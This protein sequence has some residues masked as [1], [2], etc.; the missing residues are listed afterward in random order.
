MRRKLSYMCFGLS[1]FFLGLGKFL[2]GGK[3]IICD[4]LTLSGWF[5]IDCSLIKQSGLKNGFQWETWALPETYVKDMDKL[6][7]NKGK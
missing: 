6:K 4:P 7:R 2:R 3:T 1:S 5:V